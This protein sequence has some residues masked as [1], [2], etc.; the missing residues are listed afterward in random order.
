MTFFSNVEKYYAKIHIETQEDL[1]QSN[2]NNK[3]KTGGIIIP[4]F[5]VH[6]RALVIKAAMYWPKNR[7]V[8]Q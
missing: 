5:K 8:V 4:D 6:Y 2:C 3:N 1:N 7:H